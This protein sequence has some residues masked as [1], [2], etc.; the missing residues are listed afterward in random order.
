MAT[1]PRGRASPAR[2]LAM[3]RSPAPAAD[4]TLAGAG[5]VPSRPVERATRNGRIVYKQ[6]GRVM[7][8]VG[9]GARRAACRSSRAARSTSARARAARW[10]R[11]YAR[12]GDLFTL[13]LRRRARAPAHPHGRA[14]A[15][16]VGVEGPGRVRARPA[17]VRC[18]RSA[19]ARRARSAAAAATTT[20]WTSTAAGWRSRASAARPTAPSGRCSPRAAAAWR[21]WSTAPR[22]AC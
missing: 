9:D 8:R 11:A 17:P 12:G 2:P 3:R 10:S 16:P 20:R 13:R 15:A 19:K 22:A 6:D 1:R 14:R 21:G 5:A 4:E 18:G 7:T